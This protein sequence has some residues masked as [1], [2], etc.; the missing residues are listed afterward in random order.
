MTAHYIAKVVESLYDKLDINKMSEGFDKIEKYNCGRLS[1]EWVNRE[2]NEK[3]YIRWCYAIGTLETY[4]KQNL[5]TFEETE[6]VY[7]WAKDIC[8]QRNKL[9]NQWRAFGW[10]MTFEQWLNKK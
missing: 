6:L 8:E 2:I 9:Y 1:D 4:C 10:Y 7:K 5:A 3:S